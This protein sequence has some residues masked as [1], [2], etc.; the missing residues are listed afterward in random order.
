M[1]S[2][3]LPLI[4]E[5]LPLCSGNPVMLDTLLSLASRRDVDHV[6]AAAGAPNPYDTALNEVQHYVSSLDD[7]DLADPLRIQ[8]PISTVLLLTILSFAGPSED[9]HHH[10]SRVVSLIDCI[11]L[12]GMKAS[13]SG[14]FLLMC[15]AHLDIPA[16]SVGKT[17]SSLH[18]WTKWDLQ[19]TNGQVSTDGSH[20][21]SSFL[22]F[23]VL[24]GYPVSLVSL[25][26]EASMSADRSSVDSS[27]PA[28]QRY[29]VSSEAESEQERDLAWK[30]QLTLEAWRMPPVPPNMTPMERQALY[31]GWKTMHKATMLFHMRRKGFRSNLL[32]LLPTQLAEGARGL[33]ED[34]VIGVR[35][36][37]LCWES[38]QVPMANAMAWPIAV[39]GCECGIPG[40]EA[41]TDDVDWC[42]ERMIKYFDM[43]H[44]AHL[45]TLLTSVWA[46]KQRITE[47]QQGLFMSLELAA[48][49]RQLTVPLF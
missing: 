29:I 49:L 11:D 27:K 2:S 22:P 24:T 36:L 19:N 38:D 9:W 18:A 7:A 34:I 28:D 48:N 4:D 23:E 3:G 13:R 6:Q 21:D 16:F 17:R 46:Q 12:T 31:T 40:L 42:L 25:I 47:T 8:A 1:S 10:T 5:L 45:K 15:A 44:L 37:L 35:W 14:N 33:V 20:P 26:F 30:L 43:G 41:M 39:A 32:V